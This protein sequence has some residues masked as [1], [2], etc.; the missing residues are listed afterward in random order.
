MEIQ[1]IIDNIS[2]ANIK[3]NK[4]DKAER[5]RKVSQKGKMHKVKL[6]EVDI[7]LEKADGEKFLFDIK[8]ANPNKG[9]FKEFKRTLLEWIAT[10]FAENPKAKVNTLI[11]IPYNPYDPKPYVRWTIAGMLD[12]PMN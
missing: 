6:T 1:N 12:I 8:T 2:A 3:P 7:F 5:I 9:G 4:N 10:I 11:A